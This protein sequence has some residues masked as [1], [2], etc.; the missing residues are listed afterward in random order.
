MDSVCFLK[1]GTGALCNMATVIK[2]FGPS[3]Q[4]AINAI[5]EAGRARNWWLAGS[6]ASALSILWAWTCTPTEGDEAKKL[7]A[8]IREAV[9]LGIV[10]DPKPTDDFSNWAWP[11]MVVFTSLI[12]AFVLGTAISYELSAREIATKGL[13]QASLICETHGS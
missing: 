6:A 9:Y 1:G 2:H 5:N 7:G 12:T 8:Q 3:T 11:G 10:A 4:I 13:W